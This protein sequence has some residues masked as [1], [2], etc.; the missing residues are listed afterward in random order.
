MSHQL[1]HLHKGTK[2]VSGRNTLS[3]PR[4]T[5]SVAKPT[6]TPVSGRARA[7]VKKTIE[8]EPEDSDEELDEDLLLSPSVKRQR[9]RTPSMKRSYAE[10]SATSGDDEDEEEFV[11]QR[12]K[13]KVE[14]V[15][16]EDIDGVEFEEDDEGVSFV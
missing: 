13:V 5:T 1:S 2:P 14:R 11:P 3:T 9:T 7:S 8:L 6:R 12:K 15:E 4:K 10:S 16:E